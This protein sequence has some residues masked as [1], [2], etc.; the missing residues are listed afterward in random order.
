MYI[1]TDL[2][3]E[4]AER[5]CLYEG[6]LTE[7]Q[8]D[9]VKERISKSSYAGNIFFIGLYWN[10]VGSEEFLEYTWKLR[11][12]SLPDGTPVYCSWSLQND[13]DLPDTPPVPCDKDWEGWHK[14]ERNN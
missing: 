3:M 10:R 14:L 7:C 8:Y 11:K 13:P 5:M 2:G 9:G 1:S 4:Y 6:E 12:D